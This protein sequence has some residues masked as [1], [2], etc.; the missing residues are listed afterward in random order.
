MFKRLH[1]VTLLVLEPGGLKD[2]GFR[3]WVQGLGLRKG[4]NVL[5]GGW[6]G[7][8]PNLE[9]LSPFRDLFGKPY[10]LKTPNR[11]PSPF[12]GSV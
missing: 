3:V 10:T 11:P 1:L 12:R 9:G 4:F 8:V 5:R 6:G 7:L 2:Y